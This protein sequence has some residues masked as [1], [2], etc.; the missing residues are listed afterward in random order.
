MRMPPRSQGLTGDQG[1]LPDEVLLRPDVSV[2]PE[3]LQGLFIVKGAK[4]DQEACSCI[5][6]NAIVAHWQGARVFYSRDNSFYAAVRAGT[7]P[8]FSRRAIVAALDQLVASGLIKEWRTS[9]SA[10]ARYRSRL[11]ATQK[12]VEAI[13]LDD[14][15]ALV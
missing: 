5:I 15:S 1:L 12:L 9:P 2:A 7:P 6:A 3:R 13:G 14:V 4:G 8:W 10:G 11:A